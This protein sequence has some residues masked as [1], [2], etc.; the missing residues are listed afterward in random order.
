MNTKAWIS[1]TAISNPIRAKK[2]AKGIKVNTATI[3]LP[4]NNLYKYVDKIFNR[5]WP[6]TMLANNRTPNETALAKYDT[7]SIKTNNG[8]N[9]KGVPAGTKKEKNLI[10]CIDKANIVTPIKIVKLK[11]KDTTP[12]AVT[13]KE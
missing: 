13:A 7:T 1:E 9:A 6:A 4:E 5:V 2:I 11:P 12:L 8:T 10:P 3:K